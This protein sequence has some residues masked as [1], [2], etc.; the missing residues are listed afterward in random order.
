MANFE[1]IQQISSHDMYIG[2]FSSFCEQVHNLVE[3]KKP[4]CDIKFFSI[5]LA[6]YLQ[7]EELVEKRRKF[8]I[9]HGKSFSAAFNSLSAMNE[10]REN[11]FNLIQILK[12]QSKNRMM[13]TTVEIEKIIGYH[14]NEKT[15]SRFLICCGYYHSDI[16][17][18][19]YCKF[20]YLLDVLNGICISSL[21]PKEKVSEFQRYCRFHYKEF[22]G[23]HYCLKSLAAIIKENGM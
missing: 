22:I 8:F 5:T 9:S 16:C 18:K 11:S 21:P 20:D 6:N 17:K 13:K 15:I 19:N 12:E 23:L 2:V 3:C 7:K 10:D 14:D 1:K 4:D